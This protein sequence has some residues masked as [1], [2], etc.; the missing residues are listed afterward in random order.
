MHGYPRR[1]SNP[2]DVMRHEA[3][4][5]ARLAH[6]P[7]GHHSTHCRDDRDTISSEQLASA[8][9]RGVASIV[10]LQQIPGHADITTSRR[11]AA[12]LNADAFEASTNLS[13]VSGMKRG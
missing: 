2:L 12:I 9:L 6:E 1:D 7:S 8:L 11:Y 5:H 3:H 10:H 13:P 4:C